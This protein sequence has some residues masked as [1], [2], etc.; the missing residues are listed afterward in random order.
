MKI[1]FTKLLALAAGLAVFLGLPLMGWGIGDMA[2]FFHS[3]ARITYVLV[4]V[5]LQFFAAL[6]NPQSGKRET[7]RRK[8]GEKHRADLLLIQLLSVGIVI[9]APYSDNHSVGIAGF[10][11][12]V[13]WMG[14]AFLLPGFV[15]MQIAEKILGRQFSVEVTIQEDHRLI[16]HGPYAYIRHPRYLGI[17]AFFLGI[18]IVFRSGLA[19]VLVL[20]LGFVLLWRVFAEEALMRKEFGR[21]WSEYAK[22][23]W[24]IIPWVF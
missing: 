22:R 2:A 20:A 7:H 17:L 23:S 11:E 3:P 10:S 9:A 15:L 6:Y 1:L 19:A 18:S 21:E 24:R 4:V 8:P 5:A 14:F 16:Q 12:P 13:R